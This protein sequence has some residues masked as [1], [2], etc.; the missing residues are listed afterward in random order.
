MDKRHPQILQ[1]NS[2]ALLIV[3]V[4]KKINAVMMQPQALVDSIIKLI[5]SC[6]ILSIPILITEQYP[7]G[8]GAT[9]EKIAEALGQITPMQKMTFSCCGDTDLV[10]QLAQSKISQVI[11]T[12]IESHVCV[13]QTVLDLLAHNVQVHLPKDAV[14]SRK[15]L[16]YETAMQ[17][18][19]A[20]GVV[21][22][23]VETVL[24]ELLQRAGSAE[25]KEVLK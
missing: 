7:K 15:A 2:C 23:T 16:D 21:M 3:D 17:R 19:A 9:D 10:A 12:G 25:F 14:S 1:R 24:F 6:R 13:Q 18:M 8:L 4:Q 11:V 22:T 20:C 5:K